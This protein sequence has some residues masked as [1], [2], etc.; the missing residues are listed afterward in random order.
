MVVGSPQPNPRHVE[1]SEAIDELD[2]T[3]A[4]RQLPQPRVRIASSV[5]HLGDYREFVG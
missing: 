3:L 1:L 5:R 4:A 2:V